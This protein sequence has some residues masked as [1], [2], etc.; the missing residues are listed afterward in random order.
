[1][2]SNYKEIETKFYVR[3]MH[4]IE[5]QLDKLNARLLSPRILETNYRFDT[6]DRKLSS[7]LRVLRL[8]QDSNQWITYKEPGASIDGI[9]IRHEI[10][11]S[12]SD[13][14]AARS[15][16]E[17]LGFLVIQTYEKFRTVYTL[18]D[19]KIM[20]DE[21]PIGN[22]V[23]IEGADLKSINRSANVLKLKWELKIESTYM[24]IYNN[25]CS[26]NDIK[27]DILSFEDIAANN[28][29]LESLNIFHA[30]Q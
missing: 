3:D 16:L 27:P 17:A 6:L 25:Y 9:Q 23:E 22:F 7:N 26:L 18:V 28:V 29:S 21:L 8:R 11:F 30:D 24:T 1:M 12:I 14:S 15:F 13:I 4:Q 19:T 10:E 2:A 20:L 5:I